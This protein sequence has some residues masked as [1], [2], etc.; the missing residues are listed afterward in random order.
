MM[1]WVPWIGVLVAVLLAAPTS[2]AEVEPPAG[3]ADV[4]SG[5]ETSPADANL[6][7]VLGGFGETATAAPQP[8]DAAKEFWQPAGSV[9]FSSAYNYA[10]Q[11]PPVGQPDYRGLSRLRGK[12]NLEWEAPLGEHWQGFLSGYGYYDAAYAVNG[13]SDYADTLLDEQESEL[14]LGETWLRGRFDAVDLTVGRQIVVWGKSD[15]LRVVDVVNPLDNREPGMVDIED[16]RLPLTMARLDYYRGDWGF[17]ALAIPEIRFTRNPPFGS[18]YFPFPAPLPPEQIPNDGGSNTEYALAA[19]G[20]FSGWDLSLHWAQL[21]DD[22][23]YTAAGPQLRHAR[24]TMVGAATTVA[25]ESWLLKGEV[26]RFEGIHLT[27][28]VAAQRRDDLLLGIEYAGFTDT[29][30]ALEMVR[31]ALSGAETTLTAAGSTKVQ[32]QSA[33]RYQ[34]DFLHA[35]LHLLAL[36]SRFGER[37]E[38]GGFARYSVSYDLRDALQ[39]TGG[40]VTY[41]GGSQFPMQALRDNDRLFAEIKFSF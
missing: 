40:V 23:P 6:E 17:T 22:S 28:V 26:A 7:T 16:L 11:V 33:L 25:I 20:T 32:W 24:L 14:E 21:F 8:T 30:L 39:L 15:N 41:Y 38:E 13:R 27:G 19:S 2:A 12:L 29:T 3:L 34:G 1:R 10:H 31:R 9:T 35:R 37:W 5:F 36:L 4:L 18:D